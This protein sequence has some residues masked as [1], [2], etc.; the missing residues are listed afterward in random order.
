MFMQVEPFFTWFYSLAWWPY[1][2]FVDSLVYRIRGTSLFMNRR[3]EFFHIALS[4]IF[5]WLIFEWV[6]LY[7]KNWH[8]INVPG[9]PFIRWPSYCIA[10]ATVLPAIFETTELLDSLNLYGKTSARKIKVTHRWYKIFYGI[11]LSLFITPILFPKYCFPLIWG[12]FIFLLEPILHKRDERSLL[13]QWEKG[14]LR[15]FYLLL[16]SGIICGLLW[17]FWNYWA[18]AKWI[19]TIPYFDE[20]KI[21]EMPLLG[22]L[23]FPPFAVE[24]YVMYNFFCLMGETR[25]KGIKFAVYLGIILFSI[26]VLRE[27]D[28]HTVKSYS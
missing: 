13:R 5:F 21:F 22:F 11:G 27:I 12:S 25:W 17:E 18:K 10:Y 20:W 19:Y 4:S 23:G 9:N 16:T 2:F 15:E 8:Y 7:M 6:N 14:S 24:L 26:M 1:I 28:Y 3:K